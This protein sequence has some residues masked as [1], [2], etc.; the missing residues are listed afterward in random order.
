MDVQLAHQGEDGGV[1][2][3][4][5]QVVQNDEQPPARIALAQA[6]EGWQMSTMRLCLEN[7]PSRQSSCTS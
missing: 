1:V 5:M 3:N 2:V 4:V 6:L 7:S